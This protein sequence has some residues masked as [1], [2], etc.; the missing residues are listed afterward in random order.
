MAFYNLAQMTT[1]TV[2]TGTITLSSAVT[3]YLTFAQAGVTDGATVSYG[4]VDGNNREVGTGVYTAGGTT[5][6]RNVISSTNSNNKISLSGNAQVYLTPNNADLA[7]IASPVFTGNPQAPTPAA[8]DSSTIIA[9]TAFVSGAKPSF[10]TF[11][12]YS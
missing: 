4:I 11:K 10:A 3:G 2:G 9:T 8:G 1:S 7:P 6:T 12:I 5:L